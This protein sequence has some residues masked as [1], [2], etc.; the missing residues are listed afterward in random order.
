MEA[1]SS[2]TES[3]VDSAWQSVSK[4]TLDLPW[5]PAR[6]GRQEERERVRGKRERKRKGGGRR[7]RPGGTCHNDKP[8]RSKDKFLKMGI[9]KGGDAGRF[10][11]ELKVILAGPATMTSRALMM[12]MMG[13]RMREAGWRAGPATMTSRAMCVRK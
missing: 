13:M 10:K 3:L 5:R 6:A 8:G 9:R 7:R 2:S 4:I 1:A 12:G 11:S